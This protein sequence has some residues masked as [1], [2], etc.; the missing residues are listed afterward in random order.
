MSEL[1]LEEIKR[2][3]LCACGQY[4]HPR[5]VCCDRCWHH[6]SEDLKNSV[7]LEYALPY[8]DPRCVAVRS[9]ISGYMKDIEALKA[10]G[11]FTCPEMPAGHRF[12]LLRELLHYKVKISYDDYCWFKDHQDQG[13]RANKHVQM[14]R[15]AIH[16]MIRRNLPCIV[17]GR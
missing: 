14:D 11:E 6:L 15:A 9:E 1:S 2:L 8:D 13:R 12:V 4:K 3:R 16:Q 7:G 17:G 5:K 10:H